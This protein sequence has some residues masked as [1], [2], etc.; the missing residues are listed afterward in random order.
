MKRGA[1][2]PAVPEP[3]TTRR[4]RQPQISCNFC[5]SKKLKCD[6]AQ[7]CFN[8]RSRGIEC[9]GQTHD[10]SRDTPDVLDR[11]RRLEDA[12]FGHAPPA[13]R[14]ADAPADASTRPPAIHRDLDRSAELDYNPARSGDPPALDGWV[15]FSFRV[16]PPGSYSGPNSSSTRCV[17]LPSRDDAASLFHDYL[18]ASDVQVAAM[19]HPPS[20]QATMSNVYSQLRQG[21]QV[22][23]SCAALI[24]AIC[25]ATAF[26]WDQDLPFLFPFQSEDH[27]AAQSHAWRTAACDLLSQSQRCSSTG[28]E[29]IQAQVIIAD[30]IYNMEGT[31]SSFRYM[32]SCARAAAYELKLHM[33]DLPGQSLTDDTILREMKRRVWWYL[34]GTDWLF[35]TMGGAMDRIY[36]VNPKHMRVNRPQ[37]ISNSD[38]FTHGL[39]SE[40]SVAH[41]NFRIRLADLCR[42]IADTLPLGS[43]DVDTLSYSTI[44]ALDREFESI[45]AELPASDDAVATIDNSQCHRIAIQRAIGALSVH[46]RRAR[47]LRPLLEAKGLPPTFQVFRRTCFHSIEAVMAIASRLLSQAVDSTASTDLSGFSTLPE[48]AATTHRSPR[49][50]GLIINHVRV[51]LFRSSHITCPLLSLAD[52][53]NRSF[54]WHV[55][56]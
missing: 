44:L 49:R 27:A 50:R 8:C 5:R 26:Y 47:F 14:P 55:P 30:L 36:T 18:D 1:T 9:L 52:Y 19:L 25:A 3:E 29:T 41:L 11:L 46:A 20:F 42:Q 34:V 32:H 10:Q 17:D 21:H 54:L 28:L 16:A 31:T 35:G 2:P 51:F 24:L 56:S 12:V 38:R 40:I 33:I 48:R 43:G 6:R 45:L 22:D 39:W 37:Y 15:K 7:P 23:I 53:S 13:S 4:R